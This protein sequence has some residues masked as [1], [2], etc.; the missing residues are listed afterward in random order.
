MGRRHWRGIDRDRIPL[1]A[2]DCA[3]VWAA[4]VDHDKSV[5]FAVA[6]K[7][8]LSEEIDAV[9]AGTAGASKTAVGCALSPPRR[10]PTMQRFRSQ[11]SRYALWPLAPK[12]RAI[13]VVRRLT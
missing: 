11:Q 5:L 10:G 7:A 4:G 9:P 8:W 1:V 12:I 2:S 3:V 13:S 6:T